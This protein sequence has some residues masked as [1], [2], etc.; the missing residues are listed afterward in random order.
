MQRVHPGH[1]EV[2]REENFGVAERDRRVIPLEHATGDEVL[3]PLVAILDVLDPQEGAAENDRGDE[4]PRNRVATSIGLRGADSQR[5]GQAAGDQ[6]DGVEGAP[7]NAEE[8][9][10]SGKGFDIFV[11][12]HSIGTEQPPEEQDFLDDERPHAE[13]GGFVL[14][15]RRLELV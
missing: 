4:P 6:H 13:T 15:L 10:A 2:K 11:A 12:I 7:A 14:L 5:H 1:H 3:V 8:V 9:R